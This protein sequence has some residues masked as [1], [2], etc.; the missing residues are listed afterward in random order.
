MGRR[1]PNVPE[2]RLADDVAPPPTTTVSFLAL[3]P[4]A[5]DAVSAPTASDACGTLTAPSHLGSVRDGNTGDSDSPSISIRDLV[6]SSAS[7]STTPTV[8][9]SACATTSEE[10]E[11]SI[12]A[13]IKALQIFH[14]ESNAEHEWPMFWAQLSAIMRFPKYSADGPPRHYPVQCRQ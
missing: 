10:D 13:Y 4:S 9:P 14:G 3:S 12:K 11:A 6:S 5:S 2:P 8:S 7:S 1:P